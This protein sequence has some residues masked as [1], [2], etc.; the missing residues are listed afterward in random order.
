MIDKFIDKNI[1]FLSKYNTIH[2]DD[3]PVY[4][5]SLQILYSYL[6]NVT[7]IFIISLIMGRLY[8]SV[9][10]IFI[11]AIFQVVGGGYHADTKQ[12][13]FITMII[14]CLFGHV[15]I[16]IVPWSS[17]MLVMS[18]TVMGCILFALMP[19]TNKRHPVTKKV[20]HRSKILSRIILVTVIIIVISFILTNNFVEATTVTVTMFLSIISML[21]AHLLTKN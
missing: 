20:F 21:S 11:F 4:K 16:Q 17:R 19:V 13:C 9:I 12:R 14:G 6:I 18:L 8:E 10:M 15:L 2:S 3:I 7:V 1:I 5:Y